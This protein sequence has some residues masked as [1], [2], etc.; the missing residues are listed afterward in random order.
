MVAN[1]KKLRTEKGIS[2]QQLANELDITQQSINKYENHKIEP[3]IFILQKMADY[4]ETSIDYLVGYTDIPQKIQPVQ[5]CALT[6]EETAL[7]DQYRQLRPKER[8]SIRLVMENYLAD[9]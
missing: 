7:M 6:P 9:R 5:P 8:E 1:L 2:Q 4:F 3:E